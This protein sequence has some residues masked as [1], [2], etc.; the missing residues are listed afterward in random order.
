[1]GINAPQSNVPN[2]YINPTKPKEASG[3]ARDDI[4]TRPEHVESEDIQVAQKK[5]KKSQERQTT[6]T[7]RAINPKDVRQQLVNLNR[8]VTAR[9]EKILATMIEYRLEVTKGVFDKIEHL[10]KNQTNP[11]IVESTIIAH[12]KGV[13]EIRKGVEVLARFLGGEN[14]AGHHTELLSKQINELKQLLLDKNQQL[15]SK[16]LVEGM[17]SIVNQLD[18]DLKKRLKKISGEKGFNVQLDQG[19]LLKALGFFDQFLSGFKEKV[20]EKYKQNP[21][22]AAD[23]NDTMKSLKGTLKQN[24]SDIALQFV[25]SKDSSHALI[26]DDFYNV[27]V[28]PCPIS[29][30]PSNMEIC[31]KKEP[32]QLN[33]NINPENTTL[34]LKFE[35]ERLGEVTVVIDVKNDFLY[36][37]FY[38]QEGLVKTMITQSYADIIKQLEALNYKVKK[39]QTLER[40]FKLK[41]VLIPKSDLDDITRVITEA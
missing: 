14:K 24:I 20:T 40:K 28:I 12:S 22:L 15:F 34:I 39:I 1:M 31:I 17:V 25:L 16:G 13:G 11:N 41:K 2:Q 33:K 35:T 37:T 18:D 30:Q 27:W 38:T 19:G 3:K 36:V 29:M 5:I 32:K 6:T 9:N 10:T 21:L 4:S 8:P 26:G 23:I 7:R